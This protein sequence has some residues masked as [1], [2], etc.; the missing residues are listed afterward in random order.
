MYTGAQSDELM[1]QWLEPEQRK[2]SKK[3]A[4]KVRETT[5]KGKEATSL[6]AR[7]CL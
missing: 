3:P 7:E 5:R 1:L 4:V 2:E 6:W